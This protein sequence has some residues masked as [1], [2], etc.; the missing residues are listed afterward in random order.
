M[1]HHTVSDASGGVVRI[2]LKQTPDAQPGDVASCE[3][4]TG[5]PVNGSRGSPSGWRRMGQCLACLAPPSCDLAGAECLAVLVA[6]A[7]PPAFAGEPA[8]ALPPAL[9]GDGVDGFVAPAV[10]LPCRVVVAVVPGVCDDPCAE[11]VEERTRAPRRVSRLS[12]W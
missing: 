8:V 7:L 3:A 11:T 4:L 5:S 12:A 2:E 9:L 6:L 1:A 10:S